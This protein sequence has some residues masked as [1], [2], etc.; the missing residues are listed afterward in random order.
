MSVQ[1]WGWVIGLLSLYLTGFAYFKMIEF[2]YGEPIGRIATLVIYL[3]PLWFVCL[4]V[5][6][7]LISLDPV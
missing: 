6:L 2:K 4:V 7:V 1:Q 5:G 3:M